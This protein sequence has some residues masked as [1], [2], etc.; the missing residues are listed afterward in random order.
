MHIRLMTSDDTSEITEVLNHAIGS[1]IAH[2]GTVPTNADKVLEDWQNAAETY[3]WLIAVD[4]DDRFM[5]F[6]KGSEWKPRQAYR[7][8]T[9]SG[10]YVVAGSQGVGVGKTL[11]SKLFEVLALQGYRVVISGVSLP[12]DASVR[13]HESMGMEALGELAPA[14]FKLG[15]WITVRMYQKRLG[16]L[17]DDT[18]PGPIRAVTSVWNE[19]HEQ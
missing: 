18:I 16:G 17:D 14:G 13:L 7:W 5:G 15:Q 11:Y 9:E 3:P 12:N 10:I 8:T 6:A 1:S 19:L 2:F 4:D